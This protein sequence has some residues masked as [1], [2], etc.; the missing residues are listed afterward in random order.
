[1]N[2]VYACKPKYL[3]SG[4]PWTDIAWHRSN[5]D[6][7]VATDPNVPPVPRDDFD[8]TIRAIPDGTFAGFNFEYVADTGYRFLR[9]YDHPAESEAT[10]AEFV[11]RIYAIRPDLEYC[12]YTLPHG[13]N[14][15]T[16]EGKWAEIL[17]RQETALAAVTG[18]VS[19]AGI[20]AYWNYWNWTGGW[21][22][23]RR[24]MDYRIAMAS[25]IHDKPIVAYVWDGE[26]SAQGRAPY[27]KLLQVLKYL[28]ARDLPI[29]YWSTN[30]NV[31]WST[32]FLLAQYATGIL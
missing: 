4:G 2:T 13:T 30:T 17:A 21:D 5:N 23:W 10:Y 25:T 20:S 9:W 29:A 1:M 26:G 6:I 32:Q 15:V 11:N 22:T 19:H 18:K 28:K 14:L 3:V 12:F 8:E 27:N 16:K 31:H 7:A 24:R